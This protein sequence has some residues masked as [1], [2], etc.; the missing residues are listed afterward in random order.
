M[1]I[2]PQN[3]KCATCGD[4]FIR[5]NTQRC[6]CPSCY[7]TKQRNWHRENRERSRS[8]GR[9][10]TARATPMSRRERSKKQY[11]WAES[12]PHAFI[13]RLLT[14]V[15]ANN[16]KRHKRWKVK[17]IIDVDR[18][19]LYGLYES[20]EGRCALSDM[21]MTHRRKCLRVISIDRIDSKKF[22]TRENVQLVCR[23]VN[24]AKNTS[25][26]EEM[27]SVI[28]ELKSA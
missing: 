21:P 28:Q 12:S 18:E 25:S 2:A 7:R 6:Y 22:Y 16:R 15:E 24:I 9:R 10:R 20:Q 26:N 14:N 11:A 4:V 19:F 3:K 23:W 1:K 13:S 8:Y 27:L 17:P 5:T